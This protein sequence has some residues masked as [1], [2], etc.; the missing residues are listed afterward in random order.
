YIV[1]QIVSNPDLVYVTTVKRGDVNVLAINIDKKDRGRLIGREGQT[2]KAL[3]S[4]VNV[5]I[6]EEKKIVIEVVE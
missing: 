2:I 6:P 5:I 1:K 4:L 3:Q